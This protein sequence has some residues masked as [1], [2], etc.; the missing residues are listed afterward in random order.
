MIIDDDDNLQLPD[1][2]V[3]TSRTVLVSRKQRIDIRIQR[4]SFPI[5]PVEDDVA[6]KDTQQMRSL[7]VL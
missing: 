7:L 2:F 6:F 5:G 3:N 1:G 4:Q